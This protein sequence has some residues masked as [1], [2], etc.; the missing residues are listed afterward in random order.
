M[1][2]TRKLS[3]AEAANAA[4]RRALTDLPEVIVYGE[5]VAKPGG[6]FGVTKGLHRDYGNRV[7]DTPISE[8]AILGSAIGAA[9]FGLRPVVEIMWADFLFVAFDQI[10]NQAAN[11]RYVS[12]GRLAAPMTVRMQQGAMAGACAQ[13]SQS[14]EALIAHVPGIRLCMP[15]TPQ[16]AFDLLLS[17]INC[18]DPTVV[19]E[20]RNLY[21]GVRTEVRL[22]GPV[23]DIGSASIRR[24]GHD[25]TLVSWDAAREMELA[26]VDVEVIDLRWLN[27]V[28]W[29]T[30]S[31]S[32]ARTGRLV[33]AHEAN[34]TGG[35]GAEICTRMA[36]QGVLRAAPRRVGLP[37][38]RIPASSALLGSL[39]PDVPRIMDAIGATMRTRHTSAD[40]VSSSSTSRQTTP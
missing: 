17:A 31:S 39:L 38:T 40:A 22:D 16:D 32:V 36:E 11:V 13:H 5:D 28:D 23:Q 4:L 25:V 30:V 3:Y 15:A 33:V 24:P 29:D 26:G 6:V 10:V 12:N 21:H 20:N 9:Q 37:D 7:F 2:E 1:P 18:D 8:S 34:T 19:I 35:F 27:P 14:I